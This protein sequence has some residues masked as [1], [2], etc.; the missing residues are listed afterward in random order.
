MPQGSTRINAALTN[1]A[2]QYKNSEYIAGTVLK[3]MPVAK[4]SDSYWI[5]ANDFRVEETL[6]ANGAKANMATMSWSTSSY[7][8]HEHAIKDVITRR[9]RL[10]TDAPLN[11]D[12]DITEYLVDKIML[13]QEYEAQ[14]LLFT[15]TTFSNNATLLSGTSWKGHTTTAD[16]IV[17]AMSAT[18][19]IISSSGKRPNTFVGGW[20]VLEALKD[21][22]NVYSRIQYV[23]RSILTPDIIAALF[24]VNNFYVGTAIYDSAKEGDT[25]S[26]TFIWGTDALFA[27]FDPSPG[28]RKVTA[29]LTFRVNEFGN[30]YQVRKWYEDEIDGDYIEVR[31][32]FAPR[33]VATACGYLF[34]SVAL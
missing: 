32:M 11:L 26:Q 7:S 24:E 23:E 34:K 30:P 29:A 27:Y 14:K 25:E 3:D 33:A 15:T 4:E 20:G 28:L 8:V 5:Y 17:N 22:E 13:R 1:M 2:V 19:K 16:P 21:N 10:N 31:T 12:R 9:D 6:R 18:G